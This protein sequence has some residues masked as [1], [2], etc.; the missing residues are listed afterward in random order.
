MSSYTELQVYS[1]F[2]FLR[3]ASHPEELV[4]QAAHLGYSALALTDWHSL[5]GVVR[6]HAAA[7]HCGIRFI[8]GSH[9]P[10]YKN[11]TQSKLSKKPAEI[12]EAQKDYLPE[13]LLPFSLLLYPSSREAYGR[14]CELLSKG[15]LRAPKGKCYLGLE[16]IAEYQQGLLAVVIVNSFDHPQLLDYLK[17]LKNLF[18]CD[19]LSL[20]ISQTYGPNN[21][22]Q[23]TL[24]EQLSKLS[25]IP[26][27]ASNCVHYHH[28]ERRQL[29]DILT[30]IR[31]N[32][33]L[34]QA[35][36][37]LTANAERYLKPL[38]EIDR[39]FKN[40]PLA[41]SRSNEI[42]YICSQF[43]LD[44]LHYEY[45]TEIC[46]KEVQPIEHLSKLTW[47][48]AAKLYR[49]GIPKKVA[50]QIVHEL[51]L[52]EELN[53]PKYFLT[54]Y[55]IVCFARSKNILCQGRGAAANS[56]VCY[57]LGI[58]AV[59]PDQIDL[60]F[61]RFISRE[62]N[63]PPDIDID[64]EH[65][66]REE[67]L[68]YVYQKYGRH[69]AAL[70]AAV[71]T[72]RTKSA[73]RDVGKALNL[74]LQTIEN[75]IRLLT[76]SESETITKNELLKRELD[77]N[78][79][80]IRQAI[81]LV[82]T[83][84]NFPRH[85]SQHV[86]GIIVS[87]TPLSSIVPIENA[88]MPERTI[89]EW[90]KN[91]IEIMGMLKI[92]ILALGMLTMLKKAFV[93]TE[94]V[95]DRK[96]SLTSLPPE[97]PKVYE[98]I[99]RADTIGVF[100]IESRAQM[101]MLP[102]LRPQCFYD[103]VIQ[104]AIVRP[105]PIQGGMVHPFLRRR[106]G[107]EKVSY[108]DQ[109]IKSI[110]ERTLGVPIFQEQVMELAV[111]AAGFTPGESDQLRRAIASWK[112]SE[113]NLHHFK[114]RLINGMQANGYSTS[115]AEQVF[116]QI[117]G[118]GEYGFP[119]SHSASFA[120]LAYA[121]SWFKKHYP[122]V[123]ATALLNSQPMG[124]YRPAQII[125]DARQHG[126]KVRPVDINKSIWDCS[127]EKDPTPTNIKQNKVGIRL[128]MRMVRGLSRSD[129][130]RLISARSAEKNFSSI[131]TLWRTSGISVTALKKLAKADAFSSMGID[132]QQALWEIRSLRE[133]PL[134]LFD[135]IHILEKDFETDTSIEQLPSIS[136]V[137]QVARDYETT[138]LSLKAHPVSFYRKAL[139]QLGC[140]TCYALRND[141]TLAN[142][143]RII[144]AGI[145]L[146]RQR[147][148]TASGVL[149]MTFEDETS[150]ANLI[151]KPKVFKKY[152]DTICD[153]NFLLSTGCIQ[154]QGE[155][156]H[157]LAEEF[158]SIAE[159]LHVAQ[160][161]EIK[162]MSRDFH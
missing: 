25:S 96:L 97:D 35:G 156:V 64:F 82:K 53:Y 19:R 90:D 79:K 47:Q 128:G 17:K 45:P 105:G 88:A 149:F 33:T 60:L 39:L 91:D 113:K 63:E 148:M 89:I 8:V 43:S 38:D 101:S 152:C 160:L 141:P 109:K 18:N 162:T 150:M 86:G 68:Q 81:S 2:S 137:Q 26:L 140:T 55:D 15:K 124:F 37:L 74:S 159:A 7:K 70:T 42:A 75:L 104:I 108:P 62:R 123:F 161:K 4:E 147:P 106:S 119:Q 157:L 80:K 29:Q 154:R 83:I 153:S 84:R 135:S 77:P 44:Q 95:Y 132:R 142:G 66:R 21:Y 146:V 131:A 110:L 134:P 122:A 112:R 72:Y 126:V 49:K 24:L 107:E 118:F 10:L 11:P 158:I 144:I 57:V 71:V 129:A 87:E 6:A 32:L 5:A 51:K 9:I 125:G 100:Q 76:R 73:V 143:M 14:L 116:Q 127:I 151:V 30:C 117:Q 92:D 1:N 102:R 145:V 69:R 34:E 78:N 36:F 27:V 50:T 114:H 98:M 155:V 85:L 23:I 136:A 111:V 56:A 121:S 65:E 94:E 133:A 31:H 139:E 67:V 115:F 41:L 46:P 61:E 48:G 40:I 58:T 22:T 28:P 20:N 138:G 103:L 13:P 93:L 12:I 16:D 130:E 3:G 59:P 99:C 54:V 52:I 120:L